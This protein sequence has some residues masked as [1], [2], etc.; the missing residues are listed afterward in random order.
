MLAQ[1]HTGL[2]GCSGL[3]SAHRVGLTAPKPEFLLPPKFGLHQKQ[4]NHLETDRQ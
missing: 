3:Q 4:S 2:P 1:A